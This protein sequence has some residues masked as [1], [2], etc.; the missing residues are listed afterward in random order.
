MKSLMGAPES[1]FGR[2]FWVLLSGG[3]LAVALVIAMSN[4]PVARGQ[5]AI[6]EAAKEAG[7]PLGSDLVS[8]LDASKDGFLGEADAP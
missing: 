6:E 5:A 1:S 3:T 2:K 7:G 4:G 8:A